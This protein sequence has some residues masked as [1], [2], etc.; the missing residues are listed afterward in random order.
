MG[1]QWVLDFFRKVAP[2]AVRHLD[3]VPPDYYSI[4]QARLNLEAE[5]DVYKRELLR[6]GYRPERLAAMVRGSL[7]VAGA[8]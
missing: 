2:E 3:D 8:A 6:L 7:T 4:E 5:R 1:L